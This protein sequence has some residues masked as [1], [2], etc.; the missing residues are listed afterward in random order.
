MALFPIVVVMLFPE[1]VAVNVN[2]VPEIAPP[3]MEAVDILAV[4]LSVMPL[5]VIETLA[6]PPPETVIPVEEIWTDGPLDPL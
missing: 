2:V 3:V 4:P 1:M 5:E 6:E